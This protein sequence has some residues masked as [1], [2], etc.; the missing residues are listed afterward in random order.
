MF[1]KIHNAFEPIYDCGCSECVDNRNV[2]IREIGIRDSGP[3]AWGYSVKI[4]EGFQYRI[5]GGDLQINKNT[6]PIYIG[7][8]VGQEILVVP[9]AD[10]TEQ[11]HVRYI[12]VED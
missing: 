3:D 4:P 6:K 7:L 8:S 1:R 11:A 12:G 10:S 9:P 5:D 2:I